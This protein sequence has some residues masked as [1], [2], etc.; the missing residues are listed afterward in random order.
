MGRN[1]DTAPAG[2]GEQFARPLYDT[3]RDIEKAYE[4]NITTEI[5]PS[6]RRGEF[7]VVL[8]AYPQEAT[9]GVRPVALVSKDWPHATVQS[10][11]ALMYNL[12]FKL[13]R[14][15]EEWHIDIMHRAAMWEG[16][17]ARGRR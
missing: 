14:M 2:T 3:I 13:G 12:A 15:V 1:R 10:M 8:A 5:R 9:L 6:G 7:E 4:V 11:P 16:N 17:K